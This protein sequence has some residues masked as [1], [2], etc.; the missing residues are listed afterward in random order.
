MKTVYK[1]RLGDIQLPVG[2][3]VLTAGVQGGEFYLWAEVDT[4]QPL[5]ER[6]FVV[7]GTGW[8]ITDSNRC[9]I[10]T[11]FEGAFVWH[12]YEVLL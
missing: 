4:D 7:Y 3:K 11:L 12:V 5:E 6:H 8:E 10:A 1:Y 2:A 9:Y